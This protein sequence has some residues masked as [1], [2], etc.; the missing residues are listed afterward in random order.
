MAEGHAAEHQASEGPWAAGARQARAGR[1]VALV[2]RVEAAD[3]AGRQ[4]R[5]GRVEAAEQRALLAVGEAEERW[6]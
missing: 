5:V 3:L 1:Q 6:Y 4:A 2:G